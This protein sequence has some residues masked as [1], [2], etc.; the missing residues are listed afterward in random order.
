MKKLKI[1]LRENTWRSDYGWGNG[2]VA[3]PKEHP[4][5][6]VDYEEIPVEVHGGLTYAEDGNSMLNRN[7]QDQ[8]PSDFLKGCWIIGF[9][10]CHGGDNSENWSK[11]N[12]EIETKKL[13]D[14][15]EKLWN[16]PL[17]ELEM[18]QKLFPHLKSV[19]KMA[20]KYQS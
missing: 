9:D 6:G 20:L 14:Q 19:V 5:Y 4:Y 16:K 2:Y 11:E 10:T 8:F 7:I 12:V 18:W 3:L 13:R 15:L 17:S 1:Y